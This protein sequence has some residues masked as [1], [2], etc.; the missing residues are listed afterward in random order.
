MKKQF[1]IMIS[2]LLIFI[3][4]CQSNKTEAAF[5]PRKE[6]AIPIILV[7]G[8]NAT[9][10][11]FDEFTDD[12][13]IS[14]LHKADALKVT[15]KKDQTLSYSGKALTSKNHRPFIV[16]AFEDN[17]EKGILKQAEWLAIALND[18]YEKY[19][20][21]TFDA[22]GHS[23]GGLVLTNFLEYHST[24]I[25]PH[26]RKLVTVST[27]YNDT[28]EKDNGSAHDLKKLPKKTN[29]LQTFIDRK[30]FIPK[31]ISVL[32]ITG[33]LK[34]NHVSDGIVPVNS[35][36]AGELI[37]KGTVSSYSS[38]IYNGND[39]GHSDILSNKHVQTRIIH[40]LFK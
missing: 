8:T 3:S 12:L 27:P 19:H 16:I 33:D 32:N 37:Y 25:E 4:G 39:T 23:N 40:F 21:S 17:S 11:R 28:D 7:P 5:S 13:K 30:G 26:L 31:S 6:T 20:F 35:A 34:N 1:L 29:L 18:L 15:V 22:I 10:N 9:E 38:K 24:E 36:L 14:Y 2:L